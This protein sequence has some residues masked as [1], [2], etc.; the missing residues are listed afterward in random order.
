[1]PISKVQELVPEIDLIKF[2]KGQAPAGYEIGPNRTVILGDI[3]FFTALPKIL[4]DSPR[5][6]VRAYMKSRLV[7]TW[8]GRLHKNFTVPMRQLSNQLA[9]RDPNNVPERWRTCIGE[10]DSGLG[11]ALSASYIERAFTLKDKS[12]GDQIIMDIKKE[13]SSRLHGFPWMSDNVKDL[14]AKKGRQSYSHVPLQFITNMNFLVVNI[15]QKIG[16]QT[17]NPDT[18]NPKQVFE[19]YSKL[20]ISRNTNWF[21]NGRSTFAFNFE[22]GWDELLAP[23]DKA[24]WGMTAPTVNAYYN[25]SGN[26]IVFPAGIMQFPVFSSALPDY[27]NYGSFGAVAGHELTHGFD[28]HGSEYD[29]NGVLRNWWDDTTRKNFQTKTQCFVKQ[30][31][32][33]TVEGLDGKPLNVNG[34]LTLGENIADAGGLTAAYS[35]WSKRDA[36]RKNAGLPGLEEFTND[37]LFFLSYATWWC[38]KVRKEQAANYIFTDP[39]SPN[40]KRIIGTTANSAAFR[41]AFKCKVKQPTCE[42]W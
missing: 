4:A 19:W 42:L 37:Q 31:S 11:I 15:I 33:F 14:A 35:S 41:E 18:A 6:T 17:A 3:N 13:F 12:Y 1:M 8:G 39:H 9:G 25:P 16:Y 20:P 30:Y 28:D 36:A 10:V 24:R 5:D 29:E 21:E 32:N 7:Q 22:K 23:V 38:G 26:E 2:L 34:K 40:D 27:V